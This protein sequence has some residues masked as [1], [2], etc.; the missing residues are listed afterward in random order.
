MKVD[1][2]KRSCSS[3]M[4]GLARQCPVEA[5]LPPACQ[6]LPLSGN[7]GMGTKRNGRET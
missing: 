1:V 6:G 5:R 4:G 2:P 3:A 7:E